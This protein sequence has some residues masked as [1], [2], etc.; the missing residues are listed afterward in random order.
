MD[1]AGRISKDGTVIEGTIA[2]P[3]FSAASLSQPSC[4][5]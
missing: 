4:N 3:Q 5:L 1:V 2:G